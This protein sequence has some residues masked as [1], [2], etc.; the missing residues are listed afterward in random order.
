LYN[1][2]LCSLY[3]VRPTRTLLDSLLSGRRLLG[4][5]DGSYLFY[6]RRRLA[7]ARRAA[8]SLV[9][10]V[11]GN[12]SKNSFLRILEVFLSESGCK[13]KAFFLNLQIF[14]QNIFQPTTPL[15][16]QGSESRTV[17]P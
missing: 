11:Y 7:C 16:P 12:L 6:P 3:G 4:V 14:S 9:L 8:F 10:S 2:F 17:T 5:I 13:G 1:Y 15:F